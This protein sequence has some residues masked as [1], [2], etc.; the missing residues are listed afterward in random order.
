MNIEYDRID[1]C[2]AVNLGRLFLIRDFFPRLIVLEDF[3]V[4]LQAAN[5]IGLETNYSLPYR[6]LSYEQ[7]IDNVM[8]NLSVV[9]ENYEK[10]CE[11]SKTRIASKENRLREYLIKDVSSCSATEVEREASDYIYKSKVHEIDSL[12]LTDLE[13]KQKEKSDAFR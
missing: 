7:M 4:L 10:L 2:K 11:I 6:K 3:E 1:H 12:K 8:C 5:S 13:L 9:L